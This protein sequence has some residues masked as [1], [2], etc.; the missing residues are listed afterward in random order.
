LNN[1]ALTGTKKEKILEQNFQPFQ[2]LHGRSK[3]EGTGMGMAICLKIVER[4]KGSITAQS[5]PG[6]GSTFKIN[7]PVT[8]PSQNN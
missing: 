1:R 4:H 7:L 6:K 5:T 2:R 3:Y 8:Q